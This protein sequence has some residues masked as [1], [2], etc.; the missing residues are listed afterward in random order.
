M[1]FAKSLPLNIFP[2]M[3]EQRPLFL[4]KNNNNICSLNTQLSDSCQLNIKDIV[5]ILPQRRALSITRLHKGVS[6]LKYCSDKFY[7]RW[8]VFLFVCLN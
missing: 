4:K 3:S 7:G 8:Q 1:T 5:M 6:I 2:L